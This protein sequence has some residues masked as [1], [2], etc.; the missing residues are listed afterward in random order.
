MYPNLKGHRYAKKGKTKFP[1]LS[2][3]SDIH[4]LW[5]N[6]KVVEVCVKAGHTFYNLNAHI[7]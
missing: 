2:V 6:R 5:F 1:S 7:I 3:A 4:E